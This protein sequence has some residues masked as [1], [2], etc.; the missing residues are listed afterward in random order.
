MVRRSKRRVSGREGARACAGESNGA[1]QP[2]LAAHALSPSTR[3]CTLHVAGCPICPPWVR[4]SGLAGA[5]TPARLGRLVDTEEKKSE[6]RGSGEHGSEGGV[7]CDSGD[8]L[9]LGSGSGSGSGSGGSV[10]AGAGAGAGASGGVA[11]ACGL[12][13]SDGGAKTSDPCSAGTRAE[14][15]FLVCR[16]C[17]GDRQ[18]QITPA[19]TLLSALLVSVAELD[20]SVALACSAHAVAVSR[21]CVGVSCTAAALHGS[22][23]LDE[24]RED[25][26]SALTHAGLEVGAC[27][28]VHVCGC[29][30]GCAGKGEG[31]GRRS[32]TGGAQAHTQT[33]TRT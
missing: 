16:A 26:G 1:G 12:P 32:M 14:G 10:G 27:S 28:C 3:T 30:C 18:R 7:D 31:D 8:A 5:A 33:H 21:A 6:E 25:T 4:M 2:L 11:A 20:V 23:E 17:A 9:L 24:A 15:R 19:T 22:A 13:P 29:G